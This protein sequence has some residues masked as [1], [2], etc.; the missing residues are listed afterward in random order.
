MQDEQ[1]KLEKVK[2]DEREK[3]KSQR[4]AERIHELPARNQ[5]T[6]LQSGDAGSENQSPSAQRAE[7]VQ[8]LRV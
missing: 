3:K 6:T 5:T 1:R 8:G 7:Y 4:E 2:G